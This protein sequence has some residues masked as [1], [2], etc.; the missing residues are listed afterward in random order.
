MSD[1]S[2]SHRQR[3]LK[4]LNHQQ[5]DRV[6]LDLGS[7]IVTGIAIGAYNRL[8]N[9]LGLELSETKELDRTAQVAVVDDAVL[10][11]FEIDTRGIIPGLPE[12]RPLV[13][14]PSEKGFI[15]EWGLLR[16]M[17]S[18]ADSYFVTNAPL[19]GE[20]SLY[21][22]AQYPWPDPT[23]PGRT[24]G[25]MQRVNELRHKGDW[26][27]L[28]SLPGNF[29]AT[30]MLLRGFEDWYIDSA[31]HPDLL[32]ALMDQIMEIQMEMCAGIL[33]EVGKLVDIVVNLD[34]LATQDRLFVSLPA[35]RRL[36]EPRLAQFY[37]F[38]R[39]KTSARILHHTDGAVEPIL[40][41]LIDM[42]I[43]AI[44]PLQV[45]AQ[46]MG[47]LADLK[48]KYGSRLA[49]WGGI[50]TQHLLPYG[51]PPEIRSVVQETVR[52]LNIDG[53]YVLTSV[54]NIQNDVPSQNVVAMLSSAL[55]HP[56][57]LAGRLFNG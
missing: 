21:S 8:K 5:P 20:L 16:K 40:D 48:A 33:A 10:D 55:G 53:G 13:E 25:L 14:L 12:N 45:S 30:S 44:N 15:D 41:S 51:S 2:L 3:I 9:F 42:G 49:F 50:D 31:L 6:P 4:A 11:L 29:I 32:G 54:H 17:P 43:T 1:E 22:I 23:D 26:A 38:V 34:D 18:G 27:I 56:F 37:D 36:L 39:S 24:R 28:L 57:N 46:G 7:T 19:A 52:V 47:D 35:Y